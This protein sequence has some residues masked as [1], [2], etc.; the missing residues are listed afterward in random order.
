MFKRELGNLS[1]CLKILKF[2]Y[3]PP[4]FI[5]CLYNK[6]IRGAVRCA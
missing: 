2:K 6:V 1:K 4:L 3:S 5:T